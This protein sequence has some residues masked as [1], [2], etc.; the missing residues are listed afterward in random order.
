MVREYY[1]HFYSTEH[2]IVN[3]HEI[4]HSILAVHWP[5]KKVICL[6]KYCNN[7]WN[8]WA[9][10]SSGRHVRLSTCPVPRLGIATTSHCLFVSLWPNDGRRI[11]TITGSAEFFVWKIQSQAFWRQTDLQLLTIMLNLHTIWLSFSLTLS[12]GNPRRLLHDQK[13][14]L[15]CTI[16]K[17]PCML[18]K[19][20]MI[21]TKTLH[22]AFKSLGC[23]ALPQSS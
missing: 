6:L 22:H 23:K 17:I 15:S 8:I 13:S 10:V 1:K 21:Q 14:E 7:A 19:S 11:Y 4:L 2:Y 16:T 5:H 12:N 9:L 20:N 3:L 18:I